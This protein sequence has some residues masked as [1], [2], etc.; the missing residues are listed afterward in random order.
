MSDAE[1]KQ[2]QA[3]EAAKKAAEEKDAE[4]LSDEDLDNV[5]GGGKTK[6]PRK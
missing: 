4:E 2:Q 3:A 6:L 5:A 1:K